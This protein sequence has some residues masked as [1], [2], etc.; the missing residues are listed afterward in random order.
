[1]TRTA[2][3]PALRVSTLETI[4]LTGVWQKTFILLP[5]GL[6]GLR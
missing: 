6:V 3:Q 2:L 1:M 5:S 4:E